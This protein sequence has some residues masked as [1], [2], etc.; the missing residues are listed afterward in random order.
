M[1]QKKAGLFLDHTVIKTAYQLSI[2]TRGT[3]FSVDKPSRSIFYK[4]PMSN[5]AI[6]EI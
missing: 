6:F 1:N 4:N 2:L 3:K 5:H